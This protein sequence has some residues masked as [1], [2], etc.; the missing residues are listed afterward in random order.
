MYMSVGGVSTFLCIAFKSS[1]IPIYNNMMN[2][3]MNT[4]EKK[5]TIF[6]VSYIV[7]CVGSADIMWC[8]CVCV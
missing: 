5:K 8:L 7:M 1:R 4:K 3:N 6:S 2:K